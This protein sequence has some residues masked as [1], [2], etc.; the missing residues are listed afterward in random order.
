MSIPDGIVYYL[1]RRNSVYTEF[2]KKYGLY[3]ILAVRKDA[4][5]D[6]VV[7]V[8]RDGAAFDNEFLF[9]PA[10]GE[11]LLTMPEAAAMRLQHPGLEVFT[12]E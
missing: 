11:R 5:G 3:K 2:V 12:N 6:T 4:D 8:D 7:I 10:Y 1:M 9:E